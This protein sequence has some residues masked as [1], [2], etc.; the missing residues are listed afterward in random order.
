[1]KA[2]FLTLFVFFLLGSVCTLKAQ[3]YKSAIGARL[4][5]PLSLSYKT[6]ISEKGAIEGILGFRGYSYYSWITVS[7]LYQHH[8]PIKSVEGL[9]WYVGGGASVFFW[10]YDNDFYPNND[11]AKL[12]F[13]ILGNIGLDYKFKDIPL[14]ISA[15][16]IPSV[17]FGGDFLTGFGGSYG[18]LAV[19]YIL[20]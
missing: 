12:S 10:N 8:M 20:K 14:N 13:G 6:F 9:N 16:W 17:G 11:Y 2:K 3:D 4:G 7:A 19:R 15:D 5:Y 1:M 18:G